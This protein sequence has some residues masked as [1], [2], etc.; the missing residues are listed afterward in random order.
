EEALQWFLHAAAADVEG[1]TDA[2]DRV[3]ELG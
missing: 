2:E 1:V 3:S